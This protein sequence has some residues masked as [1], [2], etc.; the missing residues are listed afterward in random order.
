MA[1][2]DQVVCGLNSNDAGSPP[3]RTPTLYTAKARQA[4][5][6]VQMRMHKSTPAV[7]SWVPPGFGPSAKIREAEEH[8]RLT[9]ENLRKAEEHFRETEERKSEVLRQARCAEEH[10]VL[11]DRTFAEL[12]KTSNEAWRDQLTAAAEVA[13]TEAELQ[14]LG[15]RW[16]TIDAEEIADLRSLHAVDSTFFDRNATLKAMFDGCQRSMAR[17]QKLQDGIE[18]EGRDTADFRCY[19]SDRLFKTQD[20]LYAHTAALVKTNELSPEDA[21]GVNCALS[22]AVEK[23]C[24]AL[25]GWTMFVHPS[26]PLTEGIKA[27]GTAQVEM[28]KEV[29]ES[30]KRRYSSHTRHVAER[31][32]HYSAEK[33]ALDDQTKACKALLDARVQKENEARVSESQKLQIKLHP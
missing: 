22:L 7:A 14:R 21:M 25:R 26:E 6:D 30:E 4:T 18:R 12:Q 33:K 2:S 32:A 15:D 27:L 3:R 23:R 31:V 20:K 24:D 5:L 17:V 1:S 9:E 10:K 8:L 16:A 13:E 19:L 28:L 29:V 11:A